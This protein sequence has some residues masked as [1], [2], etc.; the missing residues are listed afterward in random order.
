[1][2]HSA[3]HLLFIYS[4]CFFVFFNIYFSLIFF[5]LACF[6]YIFLVYVLWWE[7]F[8]FLFLVFSFEPYIRFRFTRPN[9]DILI[10][11]RWHQQ[12]DNDWQTTARVVVY[13]MTYFSHKRTYIALNIMLTSY[14]LKLSHNVRITVE[15]SKPKRV[16]FK[17]LC[18]LL[19]L[20]EYLWMKCC[21]ANKIIG[22]L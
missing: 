9:T 18:S 1:M 14:S 21:K 8:L 13:I 10:S 17:T 11:L 20:F 3:K 16:Y 12:I 5:V 6:S 15:K 19:M 2:D 22:E 7:G 4:F